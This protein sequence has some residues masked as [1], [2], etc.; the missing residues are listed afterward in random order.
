MQYII[1]LALFLAIAAWVVSLY[2]RLQQ[3]RLYALSQWGLV[4][5][6]L[7]RRNAA[8]REFLYLLS[9]Q[10]QPDQELRQLRH[11]QGDLE[12][13]LNGNCANKQ[14]LQ[15]IENS[16]SKLQASLRQLMSRA[17]H[18][19]QEQVLSCIKLIT[20][21]DQTRLAAIRQYNAAVLGYRHQLSISPNK[22]VAQ[23]FHMSSLR[24]LEAKTLI[25]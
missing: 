12:L 16:E 8:L 15:R 22:F 20:E 1:A 23:L 21:L 14:Q 3:L 18:R 5:L 19:Q 25:E 11:A 4:L 9:A 2:H 17:E 24:T 10:E 13:S 7:Q 6:S